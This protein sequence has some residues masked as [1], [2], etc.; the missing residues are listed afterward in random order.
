MVELPNATSDATLHSDAAG[1]GTT[2]QRTSTPL[3]IACHDTTLIAAV[4]SVVAVRTAPSDTS[5]GRMGNEA[6]K[7]PIIPPE[8][9][10][11]FVMC[12]LY[13][14]GRGDGTVPLRRIIGSLHA[15]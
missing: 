7:L 4:G 5:D 13:Y 15:S 12:P 14:L 6:A 11:I 8:S 3:L 9:G 10:Q 1:E 2:P